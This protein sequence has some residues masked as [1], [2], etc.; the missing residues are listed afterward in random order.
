MSPFPSPGPVRAAL[1]V[2]ALAGS[3]LGC[4]DLAPLHGPT[5][6]EHQAIERG[7]ILAASQCATCHAV[8]WNSAHPATAAPAFTDIARRYRDWRLDWEL[9]AIS[10][11]GHYRMPARALTTTEIQDLTAYIRSLDKD[12]SP[13]AGTGPGHP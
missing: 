5:P 6:D 7:A 8:G 11:A 4:A 12:E 3:L 9:E 1:L 10:Q 13:T 2:A